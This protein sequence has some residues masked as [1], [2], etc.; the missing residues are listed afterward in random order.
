MK[1]QR[2]TRGN[3][4]Q[5][6]PLGQFN[7]ISLIHQKAARYRQHPRWLEIYTGLGLVEYW[8]RVELPDFCVTESIRGFCE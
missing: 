5:A 2:L 6:I 1:R 3:I 8:Q 7:Q 4:E